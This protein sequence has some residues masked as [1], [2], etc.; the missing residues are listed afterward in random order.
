MT[1]DPTLV[2]LLDQFRNMRTPP[3]VAAQDTSVTTLLDCLRA[4]AKS[5]PLETIDIGER[6]VDKLQN[7]PQTEFKTVAA[8]TLESYVQT[9]RTQYDILQNVIKL[10]EVLERDQGSGPEAQRH[11]E[12][13]WFVAR[14]TLTQAGQ[15]L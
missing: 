12:V 4:K 3:Q 15:D 1:Q 14:T 11:R 13:W 5:I 6:Y 9:L 10:G 7:A 2:N 8:N